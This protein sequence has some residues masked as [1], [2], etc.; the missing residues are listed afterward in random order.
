MMNDSIRTLRAKEEGHKDEETAG[1][2]PRASLWAR[3]KDRFGKAVAITALS[4]LALASAKCS[5]D[6]PPV[7][8]NSDGGDGGVQMD[9]GPDA[10]AGPVFDGGDGGMDAGPTDGGHDGGD[11]GGP[12][13]AGPDADAGGVVCGAISTGSFLGTISS[14]TPRV[15]GNYTFT[16]LG[17]GGGDAHFSISCTEGSFDTD[18]AC[19]VAVETDVQRPSD[20]PT[21]DAGVG[22]L[23]KITPNNANATTSSV[24]ITVQDM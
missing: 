5:Y 20:G 12:V 10:D 21:A 14:T 22:K 23:I 2:G 7:G 9:G 1:A 18:I 4:G 8:L 16:Y 11:G 3:M 17:N 24:S 15:V 19:P 6:V 13:D